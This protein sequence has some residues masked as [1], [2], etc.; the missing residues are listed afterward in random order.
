MSEEA[1]QYLDRARKAFVSAQRN[2]EIDAA[3]AANRAY[4]AAFYA[5]TALLV[6][7]R[8]K[9]LKR[10]SAVE[11]AVFRD[12]VNSGRWPQELGQRFRDLGRLRTIADYDVAQL[13][14]AEQAQKAVGDAETIIAA[15]T[16]E[17][18]PS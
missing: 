2:I 3:T 9:S 16:A 15:V 7:E 4:Y 17:I 14:T 11:A 5:I 13:V 1:S 18:Q 10:H 8:G 6:V 12:F